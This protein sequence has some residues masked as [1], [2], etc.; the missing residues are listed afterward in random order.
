MI[1]HKVYFFFKK[2]IICFIIYNQKIKLFKKGLFFAKKSLK[3]LNNK[4]IH[5]YLKFGKFLF[6]LKYI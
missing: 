2:I 1:T 4:H 5:L 6:Y 3:Q